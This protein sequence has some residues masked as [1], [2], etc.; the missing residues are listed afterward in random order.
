MNKQIIRLRQ[1]LNASRCSPIGK[2]IFTSNI[3]ILVQYFI[4]FVL[5]Q[6]FNLYENQY[7]QIYLCKQFFKENKQRG[8]V[9]MI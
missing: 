3:T 2:K 5:N 1:A 8:I 4:S 9:R 7:G 6:K